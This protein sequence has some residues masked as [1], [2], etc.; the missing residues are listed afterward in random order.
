MVEVDWSSIFKSFYEMVRIK[1]TCKD[2][3]KIPSERLYEMNKEIFRVSFV[4]E[5]EGG[6][7]LQGEKEDGGDGDDKGNGNDE[8]ADDLNDDDDDGVEK[9]LPEEFQIGQTSGMKTPISK[10]NKN[11]GYKTVVD[12]VIPGVMNQEKQLIAL[13]GNLESKVS[14]A[15][16]NKDQATTSGCKTAGECSGVK[17]S[18][19]CSELT[20]DPK[21][22][23]FVTEVIAKELTPIIVD[24]GKDAASMEAQKVVGSWETPEVEQRI[25]SDCYIVGNKFHSLIND[26]SHHSKWEEFRN[27]A[28]EGVSDECSRLLKKMELED[29]DEEYD[30]LDD[31]MDEGTQEDANLSLA[32]LGLI[33]DKG[34]TISNIQDEAKKN[35]KRKPRWGPIERIP[36]PRRGQDDGRTVLQ[37]AQDLKADRNLEKGFQETKK[38]S[39]NES[40]LNY[41]NKDFVWH[42]LPANG[43]AGGILVG[44][45]E[46]KF[47]V[48]A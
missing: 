13:M 44:A 39:F 31:G 35:Q 17:D 1:V 11:T 12:A 7:E 3:L 47:E 18:S 42:F 5:H 48:I 16:A 21:T 25:D 26:E 30:L 43:T 32:D 40:F 4:V 29:S 20:P 45:D 33:Q 22:D 37:K 34:E 24:T 23:K 38:E 9:A 19:G 15:E 41:I 10:Q 36:R 6:E 2:A 46:R 28:R 27:L 14:A 8:E